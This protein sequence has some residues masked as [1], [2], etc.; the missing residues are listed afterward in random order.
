MSP[1][2]CAWNPA[3]VEWAGGLGSGGL[4]GTG[5]GS[6][7]FAESRFAVFARTWIMSSRA[8]K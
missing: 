6:G 1:A 8:M 2:K 4:S 7:L 3:R 5:S